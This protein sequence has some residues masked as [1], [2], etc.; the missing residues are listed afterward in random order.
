M[1]EKRTFDVATLGDD[2][3][4]MCSHHVAGPQ[5]R[6]RSTTQISTARIPQVQP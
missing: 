4:R 1:L 5:T 6:I 2:A 3:G